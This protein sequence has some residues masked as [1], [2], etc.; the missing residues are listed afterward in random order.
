MIFATWEANRTWCAGI[1]IYH[2]DWSAALHSHALPCTAHTGG[3]QHIRAIDLDPFNRIRLG[4]D[5]V[6]IAQAQAKK[7]KVQIQNHNQRSNP[8]QESVCLSEAFYDW[9][10]GPPITAR[11]Y[12]QQ[13]QNKHSAF[14]V[15]SQESVVHWLSA[16]GNLA[17]RSPNLKRGST[18]D[19]PLWGQPKKQRVKKKGGE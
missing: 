18:G 9:H 13:L 5:H 8:S 14:V 2:G 16:C 15:S 17:S 19:T 12:V 10:D 1:R 6:D 3:S 11:I 4:P 7:T